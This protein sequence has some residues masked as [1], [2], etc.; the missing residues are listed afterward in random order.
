MTFDRPHTEWEELISASLHGDLTAAEQARLDAHLDGCDACRQALA[1]FAE[2][3][4][5]VAG[6]RHVP[7]PP[8]LGARL[9][10]GI[11]GGSTVGMP[12]YRRPPVIF[13]GV[14]GGLAVVAGALLAL[15]LLN[16]TPSDEPQVGDATP[17]ISAP[18]PEP[19][20]DGPLPASPAPTA[21]P[22]EATPAPTASPA[23]ATPA[24]TP[25]PASPEPDRYLAL[26][27]PLDNQA[28]VV[29]DGTID[30]TLLEA[31]APSGGPIAAEL[32]P[33]DEWIAYIAP[34]GESGLNEVRA[35][36]VA[37]VDD[38]PVAVGDTV[39]LAESVAGSPFLEQ[40]F[41][42]PDS[43]YLAFS[44][45]DPDSSAVDVW[46]FDTTTA[47]SWQFTDGTDAYAGS[48]VA[49]EDTNA[50][51]VSVPG[52]T[53]VSHLNQLLSD[54][55][56]HLEG[57]DPAGRSLATEEGIFQPLVSPHGNLVMYWKGRMARVGEE[58]LFA[59]G[60]APYL[61]ALE[62]DFLSLDRDAE[63]PV[64]TD[65][66]I[67]RDAFTSA[68]IA[69]GLDGDAFAVW[70]AQWTGTPQGEGDAPYPDPSRVYFGH[71]T[72]PRHV[73]RTHAIDAGDVPEEHRVV[74]VKVPGTGRHLVVTS[75][76][77]RAGVLDPPRARL[78][79]ITRNTG[80][81]ADEVAI[82]GGGMEGW[83][84]PALVDPSPEPEA[85]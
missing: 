39:V 15:V 13:A 20:G 35:L 58:W 40:L 85:P 54:T 24:P 41:W 2:Q 78:A 48:W 60:G 38:S 25:L 65:L 47:D 66:T 9:R 6:L 73:T 36:R 64:F 81:V 1:A 5:I 56:D 52:G 30:E 46:L 68:A 67:G 31:E 59:E 72:D 21:T 10:T 49:L 33:D 7:P 70:N 69:W 11:E 75:A 82:L 34:L 32:S 29:R 79:L 44:V 80:D 12:W 26:S 61:G 83:I 27:G 3:R 22:A 45:A 74:D 4:R 51:W 62:A 28:L 18:S 23:Q 50:F 76:A 63:R 43:R 37:D 53:P 57:I 42:S 14:G 19:T 16:G 8:D 84:G 55:G 77:P 71:A 17:S